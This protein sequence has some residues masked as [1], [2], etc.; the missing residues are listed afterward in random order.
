MVVSPGPPWVMIQNRSNAMIALIVV[1]I[2]TSSS[3]GRSQGKRDPPEPPPW[4]RAVHPRRL[5]QVFRHGLQAA[6]DQQAGEGG[7]VPHIDER[8]EHECGGAAAQPVDRVVDDAEIEQHAHR[9]A[10]TRR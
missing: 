3:V 8:H 5:V 6:Q 7:L 1:R 4:S 10:R 9:A 2:S